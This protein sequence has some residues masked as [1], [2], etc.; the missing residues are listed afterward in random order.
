MMENISKKPVTSN[1]IPDNRLCPF[2]SVLCTLVSGF[3][4]F[5]LAPNAQA[6]QWKEM[7]S[8]HF[9]CYFNGDEA[10]IKDVL[11]KSEVYYGQIALDLGY[12][13]YSEFWTYEKRVKIYIYPDHASFIKATGQPKWSHGMADYSNKEIVGYLWSEEFIDSILPH[14]M[15]HLVFRDFV[16]FAGEIPLWLD[17]GVAQHAETA[18]Q[19]RFKSFIKQLYDEDKLLS[20]DDLMHLDVRKLKEIDRIYVRV[21]RNKEGKATALFLS[22]DS[23]I[24][25]YYAVSVSVV[26]FLIDKYGSGRFSNFCRE[27]RD[28]KIVED[29]LKVAYAPN[30]NDLNELEAKWREYLAKGCK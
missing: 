8:E 24:S 2:F 25:N 9:I 14:E 18:R 19:D 21:T 12:P 5:N 7:G 17:E 11:S 22:T 29:A 15:A 13:R 6:Q 10:F 20:I 3:L 23:L 26:G 1:Q 4:M 30:L 16:G 27:L 28:G